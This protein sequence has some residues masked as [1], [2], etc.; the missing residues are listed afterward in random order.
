MKNGG[1]GLE[2]EWGCDKENGPRPP[3]LPLGRPED[4]TPTGLTCGAVIGSGSFSL[5]RVAGRVGAKGWA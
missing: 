5:L 1:W 2:V 3:P 4:V